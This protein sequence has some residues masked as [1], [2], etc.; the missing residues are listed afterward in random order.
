MSALPRKMSTRPWVLFRPGHTQQMIRN[1]DLQSY[2]QYTLRIG[3]VTK[4][5]EENRIQISL[6]IP[7]THELVTIL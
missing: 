5:I 4:W 6:Y 7:I 2:M 3:K 1:V